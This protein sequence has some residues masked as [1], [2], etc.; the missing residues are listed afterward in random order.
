MRHAEDALQTAVMRYLDLQGPRW[1][2]FACHVPN[3]GRRDAREGARLKGMGVKAGVPDILIVKDGRADWIEL[4]ADTGRVSPAQRD[5]HC[6]LVERGCRIIV[7][8]SIDEVIA[9]LKAWEIM[10]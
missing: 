2:F 7:C 9:A 10:G 4:K 5:M 6:T 1:G 8:R 3:G